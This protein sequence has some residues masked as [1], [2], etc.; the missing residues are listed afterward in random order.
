MRLTSYIAFAILWMT[1]GAVAQSG[2]FVSSQA[3]Q[4]VPATVSNIPTS[5]VSGLPVCNASTNG[6][7][8]RVTDALLPSILG[9][10]TG[11]GAVTLISHCN[12]GTGWIAA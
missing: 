5:V 1:I 2:F 9:V 11:G 4:N 12:S 10:L 7:I 8:Y 3:C 6:Q